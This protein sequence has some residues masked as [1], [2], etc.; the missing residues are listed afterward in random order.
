MAESTDPPRRLMFA[1]MQRV[2][3]RVEVAVLQPAIASSRK[4]HVAARS[5]DTASVLSRWLPRGK[6][7]RSSV[8]CERERFIGGF[9]RSPLF[10]AEAPRRI[11]TR[12]CS[13][14]WAPSVVLARPTAV[15]PE[16]LWLTHSR[17]HRRARKANHASSTSRPHGSEGP[18]FLAQAREP[19]RGEDHVASSLLNLLQERGD[20]LR[21]EFRSLPVVAPE[22]AEFPRP[23]LLR[24]GTDTRKVS[25]AMGIGVRRHGEPGA[26]GAARAAAD[27]T[28]HKSP[29][30]AAV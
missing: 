27:R 24:G 26:T 25:V 15:R 6:A 23:V 5:A 30:R 18:V 29:H 3:M 2:A 11:L 21:G 17:P 9:L 10:T 20:P 14:F 8:S 16:R 13:S 12:I 22:A 19:C 4:A 7:P 28:S 1:D